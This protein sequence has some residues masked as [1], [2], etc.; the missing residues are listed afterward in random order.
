[1]T[2]P[3]DVLVPTYCRPA[4]LAV[5]LAGLTA[6]TFPSFR[7]VISDQ[8]PDGESTAAAELMTSVRL[9]RARGRPV[10]LLRHDRHGLAE[11]R[12][13]LLDQASAP[14]ALFLDDDVLCEP[15]VVARLVRVMEGQRC[16]FVGAPLVGLSHLDDVRPAEQGI[17]SWQGPVRPE[18]FGPDDERWQRHRL[19]NAANVWHVE[20]ALG[21]TDA[22]P[23]VYK[24]AWVGGCVLYDVDKLRDVGGFTFWRELPAEHCGEDALVQLRLR[25]QYGGCGVLPSG[26]YHQQLSTTVPDRRVDA[27]HALRTRPSVGPSALS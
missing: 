3:V 23:V 16:G 20:N 17:E 5:T 26:A 24:V 7:V 22:E 6:Q 27:P 1:V 12:Q 4:A 14:Y 11:H 25:E 13:F 10:E 18:P 2:L 19:H 8:S 9:L 15:G 21:A